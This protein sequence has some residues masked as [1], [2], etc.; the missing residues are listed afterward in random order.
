MATIKSYTD[1]EQSKKLVEILPPESADMEYFFFTDDKI[2]NGGIPFIKDGSKAYLFK[3]V[4]CWSIAALLELLHRNEK[5]IMSLSHGCYIDGVY[6]Q[7]YSTDYELE[8]GNYLHTYADNPIDA[9][10]ELILKLHE[11]NLL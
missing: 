5:D 9:C 1:L 3:R 7:I 10:Y 6:T 4:P 11:Q 2:M 8:D